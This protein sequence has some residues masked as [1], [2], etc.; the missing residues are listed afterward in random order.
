MIQ[1][2]LAVVALC[3]L[4]TFESTVK[5]TVAHNTNTTATSAFKFKDVPPPAKDDAASGSK[6]LLL[7]GETDPNGSDL[8]VL[9][10]GLTPND[11]DQ[12]AANFFFDAGTGGGRFRIDLGSV[13]NIAEVNTY[14]WHPNTRGPQVYRLWASDGSDPKFNAEP[15]GT[16][17]P[18]SC[19]W[20]TITVVDTRSKEG[21]DGGQYGVSITDT[22]ASLGKYRYLL[23]DCYATEVAD[24]WGNT[25]YSEVDVV[26]K[27]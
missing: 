12:P 7:D 11:E 17:D 5:V 20:K 4:S 16:I 25:F 9:T 15:K 8:S 24:N 6:L 22:G 13:M 1:V 27:K 18:A 26:A 19:G 10:D 21:D 3:L 14:S 23:F 2:A